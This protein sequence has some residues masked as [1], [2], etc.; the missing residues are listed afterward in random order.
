MNN[1]SENLVRILDW[2]TR[3]IEQ[4]LGFPGGK[5]TDVN[6]WLCFLSAILLTSGFYGLLIASGEAV[7][8]SLFAAIFI[9]RGVTPYLM[10]FL[11]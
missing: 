10:I 1:T 4:H 8:S 9:D 11:T 6:N 3:D 2:R 5:Y 7:R